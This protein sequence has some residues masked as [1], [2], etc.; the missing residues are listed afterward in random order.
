MY[1]AGAPLK[2]DDDYFYFWRNKRNT[3]PPLFNSSATT[4]SSQQSPPNIQ[5]SHSLVSS[6]FRHWRKQNHTLSLGLCR[7]NSALEISILDITTVPSNSVEETLKCNSDVLKNENTSSLCYRLDPEMF[8]YLRWLIVTGVSVRK[9]QKDV[10]IK[11]NEFLF[12]AVS[13]TTNLLQAP[14]DVSSNTN[15]RSKLL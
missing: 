11:P 2:E 8:A 9:Q 15:N 14:L 7:K 10:S 1:V 5:L 4:N 13:N 6:V 12:S 3:A